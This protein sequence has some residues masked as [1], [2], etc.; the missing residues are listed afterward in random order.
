MLV[1]CYALVDCRTR[2][3]KFKFPNKPILGRKGSIVV[4]KG[5]FII[6]HLFI[7][8]LKSREIF[9]NG[10]IYYLVLVK[11]SNSETLFIYSVPVVYEFPKVFP[12]NFLGFFLIER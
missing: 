3:V 10:Y 11:N 6:Y 4:L 7:I 5:L 8:Y 9:S 2:V 12:N 1:Y